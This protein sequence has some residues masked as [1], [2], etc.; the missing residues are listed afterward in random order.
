MRSLLNPVLTGARTEEKP[1]PNPQYQAIRRYRTA[2]I[3][4]MKNRDQ[5][6]MDFCTDKI[7]KIIKYN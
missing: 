5:L 4:A 3:I 7:F 6:T 2:Y 1:M